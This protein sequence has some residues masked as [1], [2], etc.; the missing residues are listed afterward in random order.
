MNLPSF[1]PAL[2]IRNKLFLSL[3]IL[4]LVFML[5]SAGLNLFFLENYYV[6]QKKEALILAAQN[7]DK[8]YSDDAEDLALDL[9]RLGA[10]LG[11]GILI[12]SPDGIIKYSSFNRTINQRL[13]PPPKN[14]PPDNP[15]PPRP[16]HTV[17]SL[18]TIDSRT[19][20]ELQNDSHLR[21]DFFLLQRQLHN[22]DTLILRQ[23]LA[24]IRES[25]TTAAQFTLLTGTLSLL[26]A[27]IWAFFFAGKITRP[28][29]DLNHVAQNMTHLDFSRKCTISSKDELGELGRSINL[30]SDQLDN[31]IAKLNQTNRQLQADVERERQLDK[32]R[33][34]FVSSVSHEL[35]TP[36]ALI[37][38]YAE[39]LRENVANDEES[40]NFYCSVIIDET[41][42]M[43]HLVKDL[44]NLSQIESGLFQL[45]KVDFDLNASIETLASKYQHLL[46]EYSITL[47]TELPPVTMVHADPLR[48]EQI[49]VNLLD[50]AL[51]HADFDKIVKISVDSAEPNIRV[52]IFNTGKAIP[53]ASLEKIWTSFYKV[54]E[55]RTRKNNSYGLGLSI[56][57]AIQ[58]LHGSDYGA[59]NLPE[60]VVF[61]F[62]L[63]KSADE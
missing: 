14:P 16:A 3:A 19:T 11:T 13:Q 30:L 9:E 38:G 32:M 45:K 25:A 44:L 4:G 28:I 23:P 59:K 61:W 6:S 48:I 50:N 12:R 26:G 35:K 27:G 55:A 37:G 56:V 8:L 46:K 29:R 17:K 62:D 18:E 52:H 1:T 60:G 41:E 2:S 49:L 7:I 5:L 15:S 39:G 22:G 42:K 10:T 33:Q 54:D 57:R 63:K 36:L 31:A 20:L 43:D 34:T 51:D 47:K 24:P 58:D 40:R 21:I 53:E